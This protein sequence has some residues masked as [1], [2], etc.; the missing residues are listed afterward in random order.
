[1][2]ALSERFLDALKYPHQIVTRVTCTIGSSVEEV[3]ITR[4]GTVTVDGTNRVRRR[5]N[6]SIIGSR[7]FI[8]KMRTPGAVFRINHGLRFTSDEELVPVFTGELS[9]GGQGFG[10]QEAAFTLLDWGAWLARTPLTSPYTPVS[11]TSRVAAVQTLVAQGRP[12]TTFVNEVGGGGQVGQSRMWEGNRLD[13]ISEILRD[14]TAVG[15][16]LPDGSWVTRRL[17]TLETPAVWTIAPGD[18]GTL[19]GGS[20]N[21][22]LEVGPNTIIVRP[23]AW[24][25]SWTQQVVSITDTNDPRH[26]SKVGVIPKVVESATL[27]T[28]VE[29]RLLGRAQLSAW[30]GVQDNLQLDAIS[31]PALEAGDVIRV[32]TPTVGEDAAEAFQHYVNGFTLNLATGGMSVST[33][34]QVAD[35]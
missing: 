33:R 9:P 21:Q 25:Q 7:S 34:R 15:F 22:A 26:P 2:W 28:A 12:G 3:P 32:I 11:T 29:A 16:F 20:N 13:A 5:A 31:N 4:A 24:W 35:G 18:G 19:S 23:T 27:G 6:I 14:A 30:E 10:V 1:M 17:P 8:K